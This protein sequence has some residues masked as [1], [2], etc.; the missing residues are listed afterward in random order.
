MR[1]KKASAVGQQELEVGLRSTPY[2]LAHVTGLK[3]KGIG[4]IIQTLCLFF[5]S[6]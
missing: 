1:R 5:A 2:R 6:Y 3:P 4:Y